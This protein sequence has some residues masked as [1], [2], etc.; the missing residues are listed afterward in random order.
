MGILD[1]MSRLIRANVNDLIDRAED[2]EKMLNELLR[3]MNASISDARGQVA[4]MIAQ[5]KIV[6]GDLEEARRDTSQ[7]QEKAELAVTRGRDD[8]AREALRRKN[9]AQE[10]ADVYDHQLTSQREMVEKLKRQLQVLEAKYQEAESKKSIL[11]A[12]HRRAQSQQRINETFSSL[13]EL[14]AASE[15]DRMERQI[16]GEEAHAMAVE[17]LEQDSVEWQFAELETNSD[18]ESELAALKASIGST[19]AKSL[20]EGSGSGTE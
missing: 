3:E 6:E 20:S 17:E 8:L 1:R 7:W 9:D 2:P 11:I 19:D 10:L 12:R 14:S 13:P 16:R 18:V 15:L 4:N 5:E